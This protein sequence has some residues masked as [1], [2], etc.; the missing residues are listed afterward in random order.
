MEELYCIGCGIKLQD[1]DENKEGYVNKN[2]LKRDFILCKRCYQLKHYGKF[3]KSNEVKNSITLL[4][5][6]ATK[7]DLIVLICDVALALTPLNKTLLELNSYKN[8]IMVANRYDLYKDYLSLDKCHN[9]LIKNAKENKINFKDIFIINDN[10]EE[11]FDYLDNNSINKNIY[12]IGLENAGKTTFLNKILEKVAH[13]KTN[14][15]TNSKYPGTTI[16]LIKINLTDNTYLIDTPGLRSKGNYLNH[17]SLDF[18]KKFVSNYKIKASAYQLN[19]NQSLII[20]NIIKFDFISGEKQTII[21]YGPNCLELLRCKTINSNKTFNNQINT[22]K[23][24]EDSITNISKLEK[25]VIKIITP[26]KIDLIIE[27]IGFICLSK[28][29]YNIYTLKGVNI[30]TRKAMI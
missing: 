26:Y 21:F 19:E 13:E 25:K 9:F 12:L 7:D 29:L 16:D 6:N 22:L 27:G 8:V 28:G 4:H 17:L 1:E 30:L 15:L 3:I 11:I 2:A 14:L 5:E 24:K 20:S 23:L 18:I 10:I